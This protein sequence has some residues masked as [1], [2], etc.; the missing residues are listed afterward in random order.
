M[1]HYKPIGQAHSDY[2]KAMKLKHEGITQLSF[3]IKEYQLALDMSSIEYS[4]T[5]P[6]DEALA[7]RISQNIRYD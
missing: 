2:L 6:T 1:A 7:K 3:H 5:H 4:V